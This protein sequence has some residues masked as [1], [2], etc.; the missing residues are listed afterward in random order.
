MK[1]TFASLSKKRDEKEK[2]KK[3]TKMAVAKLFAFHA[4]A[5]RSR[6]LEQMKKGRFSLAADGSND[7]G[8]VKLNPFLI[9]LFDDDLD[10]VNVQL[11]DMCCSKSGT[12][13][14][15]FENI[16]N[17]IRSNETDWSSCVGLSLDNTLVNL[18][19]PNSIMTR[20]QPVSNSIYINGCL[21]YIAH[22]TA[23]EDA[24][25]FMLESG[26][27]V[28]D[29]LVDIFYWFDRSLKRKVGRVFFFL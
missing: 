14:I 25:M 15:L 28:E 8:L 16:S 7:E 5:S 11:L 3:K 26:F 23:N 13:D 21:C 18:S 24:E 1:I 19:R 2:K 10:Y 27:D 4:D 29:V 12:A 17:A 6:L 22:N 9:R 20:M